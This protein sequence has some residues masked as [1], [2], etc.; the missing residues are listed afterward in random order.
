[1]SLRQLQKL[2]D[3]GD[4]RVYQKTIQRLIKRISRKY[5]LMSFEDL[6]DYLRTFDAAPKTGISSE[7]IIASEKRPIGQKASST[8][9]PTV[10]AIRA[11]G[12]LYQLN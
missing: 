1:M 8:E 4:K 7:Q 11:N 5:T 2:L 9:R 3:S 12:L 6:I 10:G